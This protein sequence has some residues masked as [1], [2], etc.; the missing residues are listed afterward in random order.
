VIATFIER[1]ASQRQTRVNEFV[2]TNLE[3]VMSFVNVKNSAIHATRARRALIAF[4]VT[5]LSF[6]A[7][8]VHAKPI[9]QVEVSLAGLDLSQP[10]DAQQAYAKL[11]NAARHVC[12][13]LDIMEPRGMKSR[14]QCYKIALANAVSSVNN[15]YLTQLHQSDKR[16][17][18]AQGVL[19]RSNAS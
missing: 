1:L 13:H 15:A 10:H 5:V 12:Q 7:G 4:G 14:N 9:T 17:R 11:N 8:I 2:R 6:G 19:E 3:K 16:V 18:L